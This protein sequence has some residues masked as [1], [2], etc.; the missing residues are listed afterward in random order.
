MKTTLDISDDL[1][2][3]AKDL[4]RERNTSLRRVVEE[5]LTAVLDAEERTARPTI[6]AVTFKG[7]GLQTEFADKGWHAIEEAIYP[8][9]KQ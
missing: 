9:V 2:L 4:A 1:F 7:K 5:G 6:N 8:A 3:R